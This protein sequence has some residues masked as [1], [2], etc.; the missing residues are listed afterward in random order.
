[1]AYVIPTGPAVVG[2]ETVVLPAVARLTRR[3][4]GASVLV[5]APPCSV[6]SAGYTGRLWSPSHRRTRPQYVEITV[7]LRSGRQFVRP[8]PDD[9][10]DVEVVLDLV[11]L[12]IT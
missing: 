2:L 3:M 7:S 4:A 12:T 1:M 5:R 10:D 9:W 11:N 8:I 6:G